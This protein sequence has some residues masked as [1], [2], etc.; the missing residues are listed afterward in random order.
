MRSVA[1]CYFYKL[2]TAQ[3]AYN[4]DCNITY[5]TKMHFKQI[6]IC[7]CWRKRRIGTG[8]GCKA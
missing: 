2:K 8:V 3:K 4:A 6:S 1:Q 5:N 7:A